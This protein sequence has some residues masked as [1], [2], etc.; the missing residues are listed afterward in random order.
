[1][2]RGDPGQKNDKP[3][4]NWEERKASDRTRNAA[5]KVLLLLMANQ[6]DQERYRSCT[7]KLHM[8]PDCLDVQTFS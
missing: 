3:G 5:L 6:G 1:L 7:S 4:R 8:G 2:R